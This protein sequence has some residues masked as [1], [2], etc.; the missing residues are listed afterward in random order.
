[1]TLGDPAGASCATGTPLNYA[2]SI[3]PQ[4]VVARV[5]WA[6]DYAR[7]RRSVSWRIDVSRSRGC[8]PR[9]LSLLSVLTFACCY[10]PYSALVTSVAVQVPRY[11]ASHLNLGAVARRGISVSSS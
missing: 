10:L 1:M 8:A 2:E 7:Q 9:E 4:R 6:P 11:F 3:A 5:A